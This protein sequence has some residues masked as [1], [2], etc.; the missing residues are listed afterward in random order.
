[1]NWNKDI[2]KQDMLEAMQYRSKSMFVE[3]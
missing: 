2:E 1:L 3:E